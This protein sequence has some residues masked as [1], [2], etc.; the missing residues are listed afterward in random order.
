VELRPYFTQLCESLG[1]SMIRDHDQQSIEVSGDDSTVRADVSVSLG[2]IVTELVI[3]A[4]KHAFPE[5]RPGKIKVDYQSGAGDWMLSVEDNGVGMTPGPTDAK[6]GLGTSLVEALSRQ[7]QARV[8]VMGANPGTRVEISHKDS[9]RDQ[10]A[11]A[12]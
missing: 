2:L 8:E 11:E 6:P 12:I 1:A 4:L 7:L 5:G 10:R 9:E 3:N